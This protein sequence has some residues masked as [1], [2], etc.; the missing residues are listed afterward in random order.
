MQA[1]NQQLAT[2]A[3]RAE[4]EVRRMCERFPFYA[5]RLASCEKALATA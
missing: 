5:T 2:L 1:A 3:S 4:G